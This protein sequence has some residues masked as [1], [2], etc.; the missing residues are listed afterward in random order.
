MFGLTLL[1]FF[2]FWVKNKLKK[3]LKKPKRGF[4]NS[5]DNEP[6]QKQAFSLLF[7]CPIL[8]TYRPQA[9]PEPI[10]GIS[11]DFFCPKKFEFLE[12]NEQRLFFLKTETAEITT[13]IF[14][15]T[16]PE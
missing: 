4:F 14:Y 1:F 2:L 5:T 15:P 9:N 6:P 8:T 13:F 3:P 7:F 16:K 11:M 12:Q 10:G